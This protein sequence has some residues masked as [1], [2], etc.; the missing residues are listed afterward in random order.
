MTPLD[1]LD[2][3][4][5]HASG[6]PTSPLGHEPQSRDPRLALA[7][8][9]V[10]VACLSI[11]AWYWWSS[12]DGAP[13]AESAGIAGTDAGVGP[14]ETLGTAD[15]IDLPPLDALDPVLRSMLQ[16]LSARPELARLL[17]TDNLLRRFVVSVDNIGRG[18]SPVRQLQGVV[19]E[20]QFSVERPN[21]LTTVSPASFAR[22]NGLTTTLAEIDPA[23]VAR[24]YGQLRPRIDEA[25]AEL[26][27]EDTFD[28]AMERAI[29]HLLQ[30][31]PER[32]R[33]QV[34]PV[35]GVNYSWT[36]AETE[37]LS[38]AQKQLLRMGPG[39]AVRVQT[40]LRRFA[41]ALG[42]PAERLPQVG[43]TQ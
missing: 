8:I 7:G 35:K 38:S 43:G 30:V 36:S 24:I 12:G 15:P 28:M 5:D 25:Y 2:L 31:S 20:G 27:G 9:A 17:A 40:S 22:Y 3:T 33:G 4:P 41:Q 21:S 14:P 29:V 39:N 32:G 23:A 10:L 1:D 13:E 11:G 18:V 6:A 37:N 42:I 34:R 26:G 19:I 16:T